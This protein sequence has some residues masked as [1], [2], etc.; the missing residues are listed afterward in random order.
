M[1][2]TSAGSRP[3]PKQFL[4][5]KLNELYALEKEQEIADLQGIRTAKPG[6]QAL[7]GKE[8][9]TIQ[10]LYEGGTLRV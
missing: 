8:P 1:T 7:R 5:G 10:A 2:S 6:D 3:D 9:V 4:E